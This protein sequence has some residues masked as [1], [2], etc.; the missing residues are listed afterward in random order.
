MKLRM[1]SDRD[2]QFPSGGRGSISAPVVWV[3]LYHD[4]H[5]LSYVFMKAIRK[6]LEQKLQNQ[7]LSAVCHKVIRSGQ[8]Y[9]QQSRWF[10][11]Y[12]NFG[13]DEGQ[14]QNLVK[15]S[16]LE[17]CLS[18][19]FDQIGLMSREIHF[20]SHKF[21]CLRSQVYWKVLKNF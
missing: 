18:C 20:R 21:Q 11:F 7:I 14:M 13:M 9:K 6:F 10:Q 3:S 4:S 19:G 1:V 16:C 2:S 12:R 17:H 8:I 5:S 15:F